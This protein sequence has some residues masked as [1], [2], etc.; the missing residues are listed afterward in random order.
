MTQRI[1][2]F[3]GQA[4]ST[5]GNPV[6][7]LCKYNNTVVFDDIVTTSQVNV[8]PPTQDTIIDLF[9]FTTTMNLT[10]NLPVE[11]TPTGGKLFFSHLNMNYGIARTSLETGQLIYVIETTYYCPPGLITVQSDDLLNPTLNGVDYS[12]YRTIE[13]AQ[14]WADAHDGQIGPWTV[15]IPDINIF[16]CDYIVDPDRTMFNQDTKEWGPWPLG[17]EL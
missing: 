14:A 12:S 6:H 1:V 11:V 7:I 16:A 15:P 8:I 13:E 3:R 17:V 9:E 2:K 4:F 5:T 10:G